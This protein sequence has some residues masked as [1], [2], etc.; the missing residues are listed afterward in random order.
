MKKLL[1]AVFLATVIA[2]QPV[3]TAAPAALKSVR[4]LAMVSE[5]MLDLRNIC[6]V[7][8]IN[9]TLR[10]WLTAAHCVEGDDALYIDG[11]LVREVYVN[12][13]LD[14]AVVQTSKVSAPALR[15]ASIRPDY[16]DRVILI[17]HPFGWGDAI[18]TEGKVANPS[19]LPPSGIG[20]D[21][22]VMIVAAVGAP[23]NSGSAVLNARGEV[24][25][26]LQFGWGRSFEPMFGA[27]RL[28]DLQL[29]KQYFG[30]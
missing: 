22:K 23:G 2:V 15:L 17:G 11:D 14:I 27:A 30:K 1:L 13:D 12:E 8:S 21:R 3:S 29:V 24:I 5:E 16:L 25:G 26:V 18:I 7:S 20:P 9:Q 28:E 6:T 4:P 10:Y 19:T